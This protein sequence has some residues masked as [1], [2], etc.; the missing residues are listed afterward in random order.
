MS[1]TTPVPSP[2][3]GDAVSGT[4]TFCD[5]TNCSP[6]KSVSNVN[7]T[8]VFSDPNF[9]YRNTL[10]TSITR[11]TRHYNAI[12]PKTISDLS[13]TFTFSHQQDKTMETSAQTLI[14][15]SEISQ[16]YAGNYR[17]LQNQ[18]IMNMNSGFV[19]EDEMDEEDDEIYDDNS[20][21]SPR[22]CSKR[23]VSERPPSPAVV[24]KRRLAANARERRR[25]HSLNVAFDRLRDVVPSIGNDRKLSKYETLQM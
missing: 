3:Q 16:N 9:V 6:S 14:Q 20:I 17:I 4:R 18:P 22:S 24:K 1:N 19:A 2:V 25:M 13:N 11:S 21:L 10:P 7:T 23:K 5:L 12:A 15:S 8:F